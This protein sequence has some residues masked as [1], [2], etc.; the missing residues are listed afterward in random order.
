M[1]MNP[2]YKETAT[3]A[4]RYWLQGKLYPEMN[5]DSFLSNLMGTY[6]C[7]AYEAHDV[8]SDAEWAEQFK[9]QPE[10]ANFRFATSN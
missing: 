1:S 9:D 3:S 10:I 2:I 6:G 8:M 4:C 5:R 7:T